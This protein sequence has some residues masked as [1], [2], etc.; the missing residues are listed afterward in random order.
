MHS[1]ALLHLA[2]AV[3]RTTCLVEAKTVPLAGVL[4]AVRRMT[5]MRLQ[6]PEAR[7]STCRRGISAMTVDSARTDMALVAE[8]EPAGMGLDI[9]ELSTGWVT[10]RIRRTA[11]TDY[12]LRLVAKNCIMAV[13]ALVP[14][15]IGTTKRQ[16]ALAV[17]ERVELQARMDAVAVE[18]AMPKEAA[19][20]S[21]SAISFPNPV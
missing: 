1:M 3:V 18:A 6:T 20:L 12:P 9:P 21:S 7:P 2:V 4:P 14:E 15:V 11:A 13:A 16:A 5:L 17:A 8:E 10:G 19:A